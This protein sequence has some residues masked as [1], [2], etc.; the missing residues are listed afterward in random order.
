VIALAVPLVASGFAHEAY[1][2]AGHVHGFELYDALTDAAGAVAGVVC[3]RAVPSRRS[4][5]MPT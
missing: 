1:E 5:R 4:S 2:I 3:A